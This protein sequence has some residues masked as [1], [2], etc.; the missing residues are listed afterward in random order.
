[1]ST[2]TKEAH[3]EGVCTFH[4]VQGVE[5][6]LI[7]QIAQAVAAPYLSSIH[8]RTSNS[9]RGT[10]YEILAH[11]QNFYDRVSPQMIEDR[12]NELRN[13]V[14]NTQLPID[15]AFNAVEDYVD[16]TDLANQTLTSSQTVA[17]VYAILNKTRRF[18]ND[19]TDWNRQPEA[20]KTWENFKTHFHRTHQEFRETTDVM[21]K[22][23][24]LQRNN[25]N[26]VQQVVNGMQQAM[27]AETNTDVNAALLLQA[28]Q[29]NQLLNGQVQQMQQSMNFL[30]AQVANQG[31][32][33]HYYY[34]SSQNQGYQGQDQ[35][36]GGYQQGYQ[37]QG[38]QSG[39]Y[40]Q[41][42]GYQ[43]CGSS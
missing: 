39:G 41:G 14:Y 20:D 19:T 4:E 7:Q 37:G 15:I 31:S 11:L 21:L 3:N 16:F 38:Q 35:Q 29:A 9:L 28:S 24:E 33:Q 12:D 8:D 34:G 17:K 25:A 26:L 5:K 1:M 10:I 2:V 13:M 43:G 18:K 36:S 32:T 22:D 6:A 42:C 30:Q 23:S 40:Q 27:A